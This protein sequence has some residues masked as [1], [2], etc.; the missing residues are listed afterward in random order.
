MP[1]EFLQLQDKEAV[2]QTYDIYKACMYLPSKEKFSQ[3]VDGFLADNKVK[4]FSCQI[5]GKTEGV[6]VLS[7]NDPQR[8]EILG[9]AVAESSRQTGIGTFMIQ[10]VMTRCHLSALYAETDHDAVGFYRK[11]GFQI[12]PFTQVYD[13][14]PVTRYRCLLTK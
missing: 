4:V 13:N 7:L 3:K 10:Q 1:W 9:I 5:S 11:A 6:L 2:L 12:T 8:P 14:I